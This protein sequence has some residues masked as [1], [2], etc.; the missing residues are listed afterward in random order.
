MRYQKNHSSS[1]QFKVIL[2]ACLITSVCVYPLLLIID[3]GNL[4]WVIFSLVLVY[5]VHKK[6]QYYSTS[7]ADSLIKN[8]MI[9]P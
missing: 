4:Y 2:F 9:M 5:A 8:Q 6:Q 7:T 3:N 1:P